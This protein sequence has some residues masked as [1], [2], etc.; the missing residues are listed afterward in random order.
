ME[1][2]VDIKVIYMVAPFSDIGFQACIFV[3][4]RKAYGNRH[5]INQFTCIFN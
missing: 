4:P 2:S 1:M 5:N 3:H